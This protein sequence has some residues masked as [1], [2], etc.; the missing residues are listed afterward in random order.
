[1]HITYNKIVNVL[2]FSFIFNMYY[3][4]LNLN[5]PSLFCWFYLNKNNFSSKKNLDDGINL[6]FGLI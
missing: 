5:D 2:L 3:E 4:S 6:Y 1:M